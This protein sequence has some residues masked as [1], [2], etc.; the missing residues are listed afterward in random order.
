MDN[1]FSCPLCNG[2]KIV[3]DFNG[4]VVCYDCDPGDYVIIQSDQ[5]YDFYKLFEGEKH[6]NSKRK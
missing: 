5:S 2:S 4:E 1:D 3:Y 6:E